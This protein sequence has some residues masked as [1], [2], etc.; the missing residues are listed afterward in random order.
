MAEFI[1]VPIEK[2]DGSEGLHYVN[3]EAVSY[4]DSQIEQK[5][6]DRT[7]TVYLDNGYWFTLSGSKADELLCLIK[8][9]LCV[10]FRG[11]A[12]GN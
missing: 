8:N 5:G 11:D 1:E 12:G 3:F 6:K 9:R 2:E 7:L 4:V 10:H